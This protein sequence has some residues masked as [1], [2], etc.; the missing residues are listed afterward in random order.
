MFS[1]SIEINNNAADGITFDGCANIFFFM[2]LLLRNEKKNIRFYYL[3]RLSLVY[4][5]NYIY[6]KEMK[7]ICGTN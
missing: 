4:L 1:K 7:Y 6:I 3:L 2:L 5:Y